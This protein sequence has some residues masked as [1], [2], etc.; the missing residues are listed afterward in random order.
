MSFFERLLCSG[1]LLLAF[2]WL[3]LAI[4]M[5]RRRSLHL[6]AHAIVSAVGI[7]GLA[8]GVASGNPE[9]FTSVLTAV[10]FAGARALGWIAGLLGIMYGRFEV[11]AAISGQSH[12][13]VR[14][15]SW[16]I[17]FLVLASAM[18]LWWLLLALSVL[19]FVR[20]FSYQ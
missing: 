12:G 11:L 4:A 18:Y 15:R 1:V 16:L 3:L 8:F 6:G 19:F 2:Y 20:K 14:G 5:P 13:R 7:L 10:V 17:W 9:R